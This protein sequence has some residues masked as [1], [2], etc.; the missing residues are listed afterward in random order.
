MDMQQIMEQAR[1]M[2]QQLES[3]QNNMGNISV[4]ASAGG[5]MVEVTATADMKLTS[6]KID[7]D[8]VDPQ[9]VEMLED[10]V[11]TAVN[12]VLEKANQVAND[13]VAGITGGLNIPGMF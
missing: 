11:L 2:Q 12:A 1:L 9:D 3:A 6:I 10:L 8:A 7:P 5:G 13:Q 4:S